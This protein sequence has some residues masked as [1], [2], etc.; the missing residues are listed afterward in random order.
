MKK[1]KNLVLFSKHR[2]RKR[3]IPDDTKVE[4]EINSLLHTVQDKQ[5]NKK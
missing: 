1:K 3:T 2:K 5:I 4:E